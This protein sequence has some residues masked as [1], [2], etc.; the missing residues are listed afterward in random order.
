MN[1][2]GG[3]LWRSLSRRALLLCV[4]VGFALALWVLGG[5][6]HAAR[7]AGSEAPIPEPDLSL[8]AVP[9]LLSNGG[10]SFVMVG[11]D[12]AGEAFAYTMEQ[13][14]QVA[15]AQ[16]GAAYVPSDR[17]AANSQAKHFVIYA[18]DPVTGWHLSQEAL[19]STGAP[20][21]GFTPTGYTTP[22]CAGGRAVGRGGGRDHGY[23]RRQR[24]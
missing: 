21:P 14:G 9:R 16:V 10:S 24:P 1:G 5:G 4:A 6:S 15:V 19:D 20:M 3:P 11:A 22:G 2:P 12:P 18:H 13:P 17:G 23:Q 8:P 7:A